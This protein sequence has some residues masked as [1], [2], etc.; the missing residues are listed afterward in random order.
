MWQI[1]QP[2]N[3]IKHNDGFS[4]TFIND[5][6]LAVPRGEAAIKETYERCVKEWSKDYR[7]FTDI[8]I[9]TNMLCW[10]FDGKSKSM[11]DQARKLSKLFGDLYYQAK[12]KFYKLF[13]GKKARDY[14]FQ[15]TD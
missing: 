1:E 12:D 6:M 14:F 15:E 7:Y 8:V 2:G 5:F 11:T 3:I 10:H 9:A 4:T 13:R